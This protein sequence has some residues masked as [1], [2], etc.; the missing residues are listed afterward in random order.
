[1]EFI[2]FHPTALYEAGMK[3]QAFLITEAMRG[4][5]GILR[6]KQGEAFMEKYD[7]RKDLAPRDIVARAIVIFTRFW[8]GADGGSL[9]EYATKVAKYRSIEF[10]V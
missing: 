7:P 1:M 8:I 6:N 2:Q 9:R 3:G 5:G 4:D 10:V